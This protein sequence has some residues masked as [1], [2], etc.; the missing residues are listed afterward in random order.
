MYYVGI[1]IFVERR[2]VSRRFNF[3]RIIAALQHACM[4]MHVIKFVSIKCLLSVKTFIP[5]KYTHCNVTLLLPFP[6]MHMQDLAHDDQQ[7]NL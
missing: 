3:G 4:H 5:L 2:H 6:L 7:V 1:Y